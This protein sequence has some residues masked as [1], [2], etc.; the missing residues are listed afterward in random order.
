MICTERKTD[1]LAI[2]TDWVWDSWYTTHD[3][4]HHAYFLHAP[5]ALGDPNARHHS[6]RIGHASSADLVH[7]TVHE[8]ALLPAA[9]PAWDDQATWTGCVVRAHDGTWFMFYTGISRADRC[10]V[11]RIGLAVS[12]DLHTWTRV[13]DSPLV[14]AD[15]R[16]Y[17]TDP[18]RTVDGVAWRDPWVF[19]GPDGRWHMLLT[20]SAAGWPA[21]T[22]GVIGHAVSDDLLTWEVLPPVTAPGRHRCLEVPQTATVADRHVLLFSVPRAETD[23]HRNPLGDTWCAPA[24]GPLGRY[25]IDA[26]WRVDDSGLYAGRLVE[27]APGEWVL[28]GFVNVRGDEFVGVIDDPRPVDP[29]TLRVST[30]SDGASPRMEG[31]NVIVE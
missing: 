17:E 12:T 13:G 8:P 11:Q 29:R 23:T 2:D 16:W 31:Y 7:W 5:R 3:G 28:M 24:D 1:I 30:S 19:E 10:L 15:E 9:G 20:A 27:R 14:T 21:P 25:D 4:Q 26:A 18:D 22:G 6:A